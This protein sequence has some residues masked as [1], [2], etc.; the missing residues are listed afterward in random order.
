[1]ESEHAEA[2]S[3]LANE[4]AKFRSLSYADLVR[5]FE[6]HPT[7]EITGASGAEYW[8]D[9]YPLWDGWDMV[10]GVPQHSDILRLR[11]SICGGGIDYQAPLCDDFL[12]AP[13]GSFIGE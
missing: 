2:Q 6:D 9:I 5:L 12:I 3:I 13:D 7:Y 8:I 10:D 4:L 11:G 1:M